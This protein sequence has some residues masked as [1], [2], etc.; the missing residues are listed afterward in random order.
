[1]KLKLTRGQKDLI[2]LMREHDPIIMNLKDG[3][4]FTGGHG[5]KA[6]AKT[7][8]ALRNKD[9]ITSDYRLSELGK[10]IEF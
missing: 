9:I 5:I 3:Y 6:N 1:M 10:T 8:E 4:W 2:V 7:V